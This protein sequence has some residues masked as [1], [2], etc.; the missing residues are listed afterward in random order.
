MIEDKD[1]KAE[2]SSIFQGWVKKCL[3]TTEK[4]HFEPECRGMYKDAI[5]H[6]KGPIAFEIYEVLLE[7]EWKIYLK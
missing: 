7:V 2:K 1:K 4:V 6:R 5:V 3:P